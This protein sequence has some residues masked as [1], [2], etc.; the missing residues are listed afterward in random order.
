MLTHQSTIKR[1]RQAVKHRDRNNALKSSVKTAVKSVLKAAL[2]K[3]QAVAKTALAT[4][5]PVIAKAASKGA[6]HKKT[7]ARKISRLTKRVNRLQA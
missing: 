7:A 1:S 3:D 2:T 6:L 4:T 5:V